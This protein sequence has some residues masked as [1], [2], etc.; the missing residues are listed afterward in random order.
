VSSPEEPLQ[1]K[2]IPVAHA[3][4]VESVKARLAESGGGYEI[5][6][7]THGIELGVYV[8]VAPEADHQQPHEYDEVYVVLD[9]RGTLEI[10]GDRV[11]LEE[12]KA[13]FVRAGDDHRFVGYESLSVLVIFD[14]TWP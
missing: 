5:V 8:L 10:E 14:K 3:F 7:E 2:T 13:A 4:D 11:E 1:R 9:G 12:G 6:H